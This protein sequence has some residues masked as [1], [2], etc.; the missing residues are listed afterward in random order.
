MRLPFLVSLLVLCSAAHAAD[1]LAGT[2][3][4]TVGSGQIVA[5]FND[6]EPRSTSGSYYY[7]RHKKPIQLSREE[8]HVHWTEEGNTGQW[9][10]NPPAGSAIS[11]T[12]RDPKTGKTL[13]IALALT[14]APGE[15]PPCASDAYNL[16]LEFFPPLQTGPVAEYAGRKYR[17]LRIADVPSIEII[18]ARTPGQKLVNQHL[19]NVLPKTPADLRDYFEKRRDFLGRMGLAAEDETNVE[20]S[21]WS[22]DF[23]T[24]RFFRWAAGY[25]IRG[26][27]SD[28]RTW[29]LQTGAEVSLWSWFRSGDTADTHLP[30]PLRRYLYKGVKV[31]PE[32]KD[33]YGKDNYEL[34]L[35][36]TAMG[37]SE[38]DIG[39]GCEQSFSVPYEKLAP[40]MTAQGKQALKRILAGKAKLPRQ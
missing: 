5:C 4:G 13:A 29:D 8:K 24:V 3:K 17:T 14:H 31:A 1:P 37:I 10:L 16:A 18:G 26:A 19:K 6:D 28:Y 34:V 25:G 20:V 9:T 2:W 38:H 12:W 7:E 35:G 23:L 22:D 30:G 21:Y 33:Y 15:E 32:C 39:G 27:S 11:G 36:D 40:F